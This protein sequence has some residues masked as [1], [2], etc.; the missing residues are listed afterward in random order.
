[1]IGIKRNLLIKIQTLLEYFPV[2]AILGVRQSGKTTL[3][4]QIGPDWLYFDLENPRD[5]DRI[6][7]D[8]LFFFKSIQ[9]M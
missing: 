2:V 3:A 4:K 5:Y 8:P 6:T 1:M 9:I 7:E